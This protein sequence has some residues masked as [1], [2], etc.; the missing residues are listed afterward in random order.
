MLH[1]NVPPEIQAPISYVAAGIS[2][3]V[4]FDLCT[5]SS[6][7]QR[8]FVHC[9]T[10]EHNTEVVGGCRLYRFVENYQSKLHCAAFLA[11]WARDSSCATHREHVRFVP[12]DA[13]VAEI[14]THLQ[15]L[16]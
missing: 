1:M 6:G 11:A 4:Y 9:A 3:K 8:C 5:H 16:G 14:L 12:G 13:S 7:E 10:A 15:A 2:T